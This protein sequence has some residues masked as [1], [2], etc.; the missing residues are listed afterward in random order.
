MFPNIYNY[1]AF[2]SRSKGL[3]DWIAVTEPHLNHC[4]GIAFDFEPKDVKDPE[5]NQDRPDLGHVRNNSFISYEKWLRLNEQNSKVLDAAKNAYFSLY[6]YA[7]NLGLGVYAT[8][9]NYAMED[10]AEGDINYTRLPVWKQQNVEY[11]IMSYQFKDTD[12]EALWQIY[13]M[14]KN[15]QNYYGNQGYSIITGWLTFDEDVH[16]KYYTNDKMGLNRYLRDIKMHQA[17]GARELVHAPL[18]G[19]T[20][21]W[22]V[23]FIL[24]FEKGLNSDP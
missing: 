14:N 4:V 12:S 17:S 23:N 9:V 19:L 7:T 11:G 24:E 18:N 20:R 16:L 6:N 1:N 10:L 22:G 5:L 13:V 8:F 15:Q 21:K 3:L 2:T